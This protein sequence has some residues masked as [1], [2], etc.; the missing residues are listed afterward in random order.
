MTSAEHERDL[1]RVSY[2]RF[3]SF[4]VGKEFFMMALILA[5]YCYRLQCRN[6]NNSCN[7]NVFFCFLFG[8]KT[9]ETY[10]EIWESDIKVITYGWWGIGTMTMN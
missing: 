2:V 6:V 5:E 8:I 4:S 1:F 3:T 9:P 7:F 10:V